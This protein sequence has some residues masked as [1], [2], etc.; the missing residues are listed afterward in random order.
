MTVVQCV[1]D[2]WQ[3]DYAYIIALMEVWKLNE[4]GDFK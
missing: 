3:N 2:T 4:K 1:G